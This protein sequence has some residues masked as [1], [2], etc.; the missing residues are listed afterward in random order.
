MSSLRSLYLLWLIATALLFAVGVGFAT[1][2]GEEVPRSTE[3]LWYFSS[4]LALAWW[5]RADG[6]ARRF[7]VPFEFEAVVFFSWPLAVPYYL[8]STRRWRG[9][10]AGIGI[11]GLFL[12]PT[13]VAIVLCFDCED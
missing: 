11:L 10:I 8:L 3:W 5:V 1:R 6:R 12:L 4:G 2:Y 13:L 9:V 7:A